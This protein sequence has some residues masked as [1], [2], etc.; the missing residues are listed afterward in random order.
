MLSSTKTNPDAVFF[1]LIISQTL[2]ERDSSQPAPLYRDSKIGSVS[3]TSMWR[4]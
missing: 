2:P 1:L 4:G 3:A